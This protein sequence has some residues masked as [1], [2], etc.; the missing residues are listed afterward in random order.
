V[1]DLGTGE[2]IFTLPYEG[3]FSA[4]FNP[5]GVFEPGTF[6]AVTDQISV[7]IWDTTEG[8]L[9]GRLDRAEQVEYGNT[10][11]L[12]F[13]PTGRYVIGGSTTG[14]V[15]VADLERIVAGE[16]MAEA[17]VFDR[18]AHNGAAPIPAINGSGV[19]G[20]AGYDGMVRLWDLE[21]ENLIFEFESE[22]GVPVVH[23]SPGGSE[24]LYPAG[25]SIRRM[26]VDPDDLR[27]LADQLLTRGFLP[28][29]CARY[30]APER[31]PAPAS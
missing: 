24:L 27:Q 31:C 6:L 17:L 21:T 15:W 22:G 9:L 8:R 4:E 3:L 19:V 5:A 13:D 20:T 30:A 28:D 29:E 18:Q 2:E 12:S 14:A 11:V 10:L 26:P 16:E 7:G 1:V 25:Q 23:F